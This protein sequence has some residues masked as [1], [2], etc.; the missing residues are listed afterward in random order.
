MI[1]WPLPWLEMFWDAAVAEQEEEP[2]LNACLTS[3]NSFQ[4]SLVL[5]V[6]RAPIEEAKKHGSGGGREELG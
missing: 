4:S 3:T 5:L 1:S 6:V 2:G